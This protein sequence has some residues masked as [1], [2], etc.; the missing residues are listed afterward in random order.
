MPQ[1][2]PAHAYVA[3]T[4]RTERPAYIRVKVNTRAKK[5][6]ITNFCEI[7]S[8]VKMGVNAVPE[9]GKA[10]N[11]I[12]EYFKKTWGVRAS[13]VSGVSSRIKLLKLELI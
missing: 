4:L 9:K 10:N 5:T 6:E 3:E 11:K 1:N 13:I 2:S 8:E 7:S 12:V